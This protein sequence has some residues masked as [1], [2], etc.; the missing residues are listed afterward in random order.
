MC[1]ECRALRKKLRDALVERKIKEAVKV[2]A[3][4]TAK[5]TGVMKKSTTK[6]SV[7]DKKSTGTSGK[8]PKEQAFN[9]QE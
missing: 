7:A 4:G 6:K 2:A 3:E 1:P 9:E 5:M 8:P